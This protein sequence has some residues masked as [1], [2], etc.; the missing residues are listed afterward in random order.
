MDAIKS[1]G[2][3][4]TSMDTESFKLALSVASALVAVSSAVFAYRTRKQTRTDLFETQRDLLLLTM[5]ENDIRLKLL[6]FKASLLSSQLYQAIAQRPGSSR[7]TGLIEA[8]EALRE[9]VRSLRARDWSEEQV[10]QASYSESSLLELRRHTLQEQVIAKT[11]QAEAHA[12]LLN[13][14]EEEL[15]KLGIGSGPI[16]VPDRK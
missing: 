10:R 5:S 7:T 3:S 15:V 6:A 11:I 14:A 1:V 16:A 8:L 13:E 2:F 4:A 12:V 9:V